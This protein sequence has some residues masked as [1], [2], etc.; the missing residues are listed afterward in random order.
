MTTIFGFLVSFIGIAVLIE[1]AARIYFKRHFDIPFRSRMI[2]EY[3]YNSFIEM[4]PSPL[5]YRF[6]K[7]FRSKKVN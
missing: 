1:I 6:V 5:H 4:V 7:G 2:G 3:P